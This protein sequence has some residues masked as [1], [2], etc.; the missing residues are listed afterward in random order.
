MKPPTPQYAHNYMP[1]TAKEAEE[2]L[3]SLPGMHFY[4]GYY[5]T[6]DE[7][8]RVL[9]GEVYECG[10][11]GRVRFPQSEKGVPKAQGSAPRPKRKK[12]RARSGHVN[13]KGVLV[14][15]PL[16]SKECHRILGVKPGDSFAVE[17]IKRCHP[18]RVF[19]EPPAVKA[20][21]ENMSVRVNLAWESLEAERVVRSLN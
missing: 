4:R 8:V 3:N 19:N 6:T 20:R 2:Y 15:K 12:R 11:D 18:D 13:K 17:K 1:Q 14:E 9:R 10:L 21:A 7:M 5:F 16:S